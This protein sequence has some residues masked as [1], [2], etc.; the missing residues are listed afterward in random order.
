[1]AYEYLDGVSRSSF[2]LR[3]T[4]PSDDELDGFGTHIETMRNVLDQEHNPQ[5]VKDI[6]N[7]VKYKNNYISKEDY[8]TQHASSIYTDC[9]ERATSDY[10]TY[11]YGDYR[12]YSVGF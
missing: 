12:D 4:P 5:Y 9:L 8:I 7:N 1:M 3:L 10:N 6:K 2:N 11:R